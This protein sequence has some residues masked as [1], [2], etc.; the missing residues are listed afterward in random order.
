M[1][2]LAAAVVRNVVV[3]TGEGSVATSPGSAVPSMKCSGD[4]EK[5]ILDQ[6]RVCV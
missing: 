3:A 6:N 4:T 1:V 5:E 2:L